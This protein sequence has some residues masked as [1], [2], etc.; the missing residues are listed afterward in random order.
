MHIRGSCAG[1]GCRSLLTGKLAKPDSPASLFRASFAR[2]PLTR[3]AKAAI[4]AQSRKAYDRQARL[5]P[6]ESVTLNARYDQK[7][8]TALLTGAVVEGGK[9]V[10]DARIAIESSSNDDDL[11][12]WDARTDAQGRFS[13]KAH[14][15]R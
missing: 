1:K 6:P 12:I 9:T 3:S 13:I 10:P 14:V 5:P 7:R 2:R 15:T 11:D 4:P 8:K